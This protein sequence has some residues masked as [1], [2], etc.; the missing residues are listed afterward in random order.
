MRTTRAITKPY[1]M[2]LISQRE[3]EAQFP[4]PALLGGG[5]T[6]V[7]QFL[8]RAEVSEKCLGRV[9]SPQSIS[10]ALLPSLG[11]CPCLQ[12]PSLPCAHLKQWSL[13]CSCTTEPYPIGWDSEC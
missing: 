5:G 10:K 6:A 12:T 4:C 3:A 2:H 8:F 13:W 7:I 11:A 9:P 1:S